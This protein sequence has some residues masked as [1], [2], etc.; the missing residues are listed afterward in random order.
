[1][2][3]GAKNNGMRLNKMYRENIGEA[4]ILAILDTLIAAWASNALPDERFGDFVVRSDV[5]K[6][7]IIAS[8]DFH[9]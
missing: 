3:L 7:V 9:G 8:R 2:Y 6:P 1:M 5:I 4:E